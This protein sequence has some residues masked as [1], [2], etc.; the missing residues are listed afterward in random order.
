[1][2]STGTNNANNVQVLSP[3]RSAKH[4]VE[5]MFLKEVLLLPQK[6]SNRRQRYNTIAKEGRR[7][8]AQKGQRTLV[9]R[10]HD[11]EA[12]FERQQPKSQTQNRGMPSIQGC[13]EGRCHDATSVRRNSMRKKN[14]N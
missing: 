8:A 13:M 11:K 1:M 9:D 2:W 10:R 14:G 3:K 6:T 7:K 12:E 4:K 5:A